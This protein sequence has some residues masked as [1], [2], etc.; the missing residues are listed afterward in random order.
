VSFVLP[1]QVTVTLPLPL[2]E[3]PPLQVNA[4]VPWL[5]VRLEFGPAAKVHAAPLQMISQVSPQAPAQLE[6]VLQVNA[7]LDV[8]LS[9]VDVGQLAPSAHVQ[10]LPWQS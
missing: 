9:Q 8:V 4:Q 6:P 7:Q 2:T 5:Q 3:H 1:W 10:L